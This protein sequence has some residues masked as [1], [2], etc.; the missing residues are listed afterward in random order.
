M[1]QKE[2][3]FTTPISGEKGVVT[4][5]VDQCPVCAERDYISIDNKR[6]AIT[7]LSCGYDNSMN[8]KFGTPDTPAS[9]KSQPY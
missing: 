8:R 7:C 4:K 3:D 5:G 9:S 6:G 1:P 2:Q